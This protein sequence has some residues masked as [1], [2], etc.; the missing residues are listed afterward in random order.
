MQR[1]KV[2]KTEE[3]DVLD[4]TRKDIT[5]KHID[6]FQKPKLLI[7]FSSEEGKIHFCEQLGIDFNS[8]TWEL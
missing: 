2:E 3:H 1:D 8:D 5:E 7:L 6:K 4:D